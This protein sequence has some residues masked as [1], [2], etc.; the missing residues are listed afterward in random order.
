MRELS[1]RVYLDLWD[2]WPQHDLPLGH[3]AYLVSF[4]LEAVDVTWLDRQC[5]RI[6]APIVVLHDGNAYDWPHAENLQILTYYYWHHQISKMLGWFGPAP[7]VSQTHEYVASAV[8]S[9]ITQSK[10]LSFTALAEYVGT[11]RCLLV[12]SDWLEEKNVHHRTPT[13]NTV[14]DELSEIF[15]RKYLGKIFKFDDYSQSL[16]YQ[17]HTADFHSDIYRKSLLHFTNE[18]YHYSLMGD[19]TR[20]GPFLTEKTLKCLAAG[21]AFVPVGQFDTYGTLSRL[22]FKF[23][24]GFDMTWDQDPGNLTRLESVT[25][26]IRNLADVSILDLARQV[27]HSNQHNLDH[28]NSGDFARICDSLNQTT[29]QCVL[30]TMK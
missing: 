9:R 6:Q 8:C 11:D 23:D 17:R 5:S 20:P 13:G 12:L 2:A 25:R 4:H 22:G 16:N 7:L 19:Y 21:Q 18:S 10:L 24:Y 15:Y 14:L 27:Q 28:V 1:D 30:G 26:L 29:V 3:D